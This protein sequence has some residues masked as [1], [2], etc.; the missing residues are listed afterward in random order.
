[1]VGY[2]STNLPISQSKC[3]YLLWTAIPLIWNVR[4]EKEIAQGI[5]LLQN[6]FCMASQYI[7]IT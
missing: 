5:V 3:L 1:M 6:F 7:I 2:F 4:K